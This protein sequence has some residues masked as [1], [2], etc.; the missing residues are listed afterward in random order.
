M[1]I[2]QEC[3]VGRGAYSC[4]L[5]TRVITWFCLFISHPPPDLLSLCCM[6]LI[7][8][9]VILLRGVQATFWRFCVKHYLDSSLSDSR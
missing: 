1:C 3:L 2:T 9:F 5:G 4:L 6:Q 8:A 7:S